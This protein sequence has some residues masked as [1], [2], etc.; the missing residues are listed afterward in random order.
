MGIVS[1]G[2]PDLLQ[3][4]LVCLVQGFGDSLRVRRMLVEYNVATVR[5]RDFPRVQ[6]LMRSCSAYGPSQCPIRFVFFVKP[7]DAGLI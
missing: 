1:V 3:R 7:I 6:R 2:Q 5:K 4:T